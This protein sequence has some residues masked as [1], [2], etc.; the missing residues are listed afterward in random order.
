[1][2]KPEVLILDE[3]TVGVDP[4]SRNHIFE[5]VRALR[6]EGMTIVYTTHY[7]EEVEALCSRV[8]IMDR[9]AIVALG[10]VAEL[11]AR[12]AGAGVEL[13]LAGDAE[14][15]ERAAA[16]HARVTRTASA[17]RIEPTA[18]LGEVITAIERAGAT[19]TR[20]ESR[21]ANLETAFLAVTGRA[22]RDA[23][24]GAAA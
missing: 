23:A 6:A 5:T 16:A 19:I 11:V 12:H 24:D 10:T 3:P 20:I 22:L 15:A 9:G 7:M 17:L 4:Q 14:A 21:Q 1:V 13:E 18:G 2:H 8:A